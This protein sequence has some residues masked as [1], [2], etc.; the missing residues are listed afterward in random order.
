MPRNW[1]VS[2]KTIPELDLR[3]SVKGQS[4]EIE[5]GGASDQKKEDT[6]NMTS[7]E[8]WLNEKVTDGPWNDIDSYIREEDLDELERQILLLLTVDQTDEEK[9]RNGWI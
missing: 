4:G 8:R 6:A 2:T 7:M 5:S 3:E 9:K 1:T